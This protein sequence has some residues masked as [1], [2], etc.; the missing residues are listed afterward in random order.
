MPS[1][2]FLAKSFA[3]G[4]ALP[5]RDNAGRRSGQDVCAQGV[6]SSLS[7]GSYRGGAV[8]RPT[9]P[10]GIR[11]RPIKHTA[12]NLGYMTAVPL[13]IRSDPGLAGSPTPRSARA[14]SSPIPLGHGSSLR[15]IRRGSRRLVRRLLH[16]H[17]HVRTSLR[18]LPPRPALRH[19]R[20]SPFRLD[21]RDCAETFQV[22]AKDLRA[23]LL[24]GFLRA[25]EPVRSPPSR[26]DRPASAS[27]AST[28]TG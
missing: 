18:I 21:S 24:A 27:T 7:Y 28:N 17:G 13:R 1:Q 8:G 4:H 23:R 11:A 25:A 20:A 12:P 2:A 14:L 9:P 16:R 15:R 5:F 3:R 26:P 10:R 22:P 6:L 19:R